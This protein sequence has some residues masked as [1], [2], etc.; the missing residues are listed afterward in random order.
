MKAAFVGD[1]HCR[2]NLMYQK[3]K[4][5]GSVDVIFQLGDFGTFLDPSRLDKPTMKYE[6]FLPDF[7]EYYTGEKQAQIQT[8]FIKGNHEDFDFLEI[9]PVVVAKDIIYLPNKRVKS[10][11]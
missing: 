3:V 8:Y 11:H 6:G 7:R 2:I 4:E 10:V 1:V 9:N 5:T